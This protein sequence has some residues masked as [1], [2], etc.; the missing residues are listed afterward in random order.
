MVSAMS[1]QPSRVA[2]DFASALPG[3]RAPGANVAVPDA[4]NEAFLQE[5]STRS[6]AG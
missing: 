4:G 5:S 6:R 2:I 1:S 3:C